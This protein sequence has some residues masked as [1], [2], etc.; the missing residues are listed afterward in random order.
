MRIRITVLAVVLAACGDGAALP[1]ADPGFVMP[2]GWRV[3]ITDYPRLHPHLDDRALIADRVTREPYA[4]LYAR[5]IA[6]SDRAP[7][8]VSDATELDAPSAYHNADIAR[9]AAFRAWLEDDDTYR[10]KAIAIL[11]GMVSDVSLLSD[12]DQDIHL[13]DAVVGFATAY[14]LL[15][16]IGLTA[17]ERA[18]I[19][20]RM[21]ELAET[22]YDYF[23]IRF[24]AIHEAFGGN[25]GTKTAAAM[26][27]LA[28]VLNH[29]PDAYRWMAYAVTQFHALEDG[30][31]SADGVVNEGPFYHLYS[32]QTHLPFLLA[33]HDLSGGL[34]MDYPSACALRGEDGCDLH[35]ARSYPSPLTWDRITAQHE[36]GVRTRL[37]DGTRPPVDDAFLV[38]YYGGLL[39]DPV[40]RWDWLDAPAAPYFSDWTVDLA[41]ELLLR[42]DDQAPVSPPPWP[43]T[44][45]LPDSGAAA[46]RTGWGPDATVVF[47][48]GESG[49]LRATGHDQ[50]DSGSFSLYARGH[51]LL[52]DPGYIRYEDRDQVAHTESHNLYLVDGRGAPITTPT[53]SGGADGF[54]RNGIDTDDFDYVETGTAYAGMELLRRVAMVGDDWVVVADRVTAEA[55]H[56]YTFLLHGWAGGTDGGLAT[57]TATG[58]RWDRDGVRVDAAVFDDAGSDARG[59]TE[60][61]HGF[62]WGQ[63]PTHQ[64][65]DVVA[66]ATDWSL[67]SVLVARDDGDPEVAVT[68]LEV[69]GGLA[70]R[71]D[72]AATPDR[73]DVIAF[74]PGGGTI[75][76]PALDSECPE[77]PLTGELMIARVD[78]STG[79]RQVFEVAGGALRRTSK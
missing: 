36:W 79:D 38:G 17:E 15:E 72:D 18:A 49:M 47:V 57:L 46:L 59:F 8:D 34:A 60:R 55:A 64:R 68:E 13:A 40:M 3:D 12:F 45:F 24:G 14:D 9:A 51:Y 20:A 10:D 48:T 39:D 71:L 30:M 65:L 4:T 35:T 27:M 44:Q 23:A 43:P 6:L 42:F 32:A 33:Y 5:L 61:P 37:P 19:R 67:M 74:A 11:T 16:G 53:G 78:C 73:V 1:D 58:A 22:D 76:I 52:L 29:H 75:T 66:T 26:G 41:M 21:I 69:S 54:V 25:H 2:A 62:V 7:V 50:E 56:Q 77:F 31:T 28:L 70:A 63:A